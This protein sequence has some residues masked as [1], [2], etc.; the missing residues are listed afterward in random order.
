MIF[1]KN[2]H[3]L[4]LSL[5]FLTGCGS[6]K[7]NIS[8]TYKKQLE[9]NYSIITLNENNSFEYVTHQDVLGD[10]KVK[11]LWRK[12]G[13]TINLN[14]DN[15]P[16]KINKGSLDISYFDEKST[17]SCFVQF[18]N[19]NNNPLLGRIVFIDKEEKFIDNSEGKVF[20]KPKYIKN[21]SLKDLEDDNLL[22]LKVEKFID[23]NST[24]TV[25]PSDKRAVL[26]DM[27]PEK[28]ILEKKELLYYKD[29]QMDNKYPFKKQKN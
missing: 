10:L 8:G 26:Y 3:T 19:Q 7:N 2:I 24:I 15:I 6:I 20:F 9:P 1:Y 16:N 28:L 12:N 18:L 17:D 13:D 27:L 5:L 4:I 21:I 11:G 22:S 23:V 25:K 29:G 14:Y